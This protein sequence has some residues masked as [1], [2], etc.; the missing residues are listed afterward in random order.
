MAQN[1]YYHSQREE[2]GHS[3]KILDQSKTKNQESKPSPASLFLVAQDNGF[4][5]PSA[6]HLPVGLVLRPVCIFPWQMSYDSGV[7]SI[8]GSPVQTKLHFTASWMTFPGLHARTPCHTPGL[9]GFLNH[10]GRLYNPVFFLTLNPDPHSWGWQVLLRVLLEL[11]LH[12][13]P[14]VDGFLCCLNFPLIIFQK[15]KA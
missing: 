10:K 8:L 3:E 4:S 5:I 1:I 2:M 11:H 6:A 15:L 7:C 13:L 9:S 14:A 12:K